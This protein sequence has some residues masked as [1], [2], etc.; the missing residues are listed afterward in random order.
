MQGLIR[1]TG[2]AIALCTLAGSLQAQTP[3]AAAPAGDVASMDSDA[4]LPDEL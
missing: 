4:D 3:P 1:T 2:I